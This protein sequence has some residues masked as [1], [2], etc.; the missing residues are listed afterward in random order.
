MRTEKQKARFLATCAYFRGVQHATCLAGVEMKTVRDGSGK[1]P[2]RWPC[3]PPMMPGQ[4]CSTTC[5]KFQA[6]TVEE[7]EEEERKI[8][9]AIHRVGRLTK[10]GRCYVCEAE[11]D[12]TK[13][14][15][16]CVYLLP[17]GH[18]YGQA[19]EFSVREA[20]GLTERP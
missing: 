16:H 3:L 20:L 2:Y 15:G 13:Q 5:R 8:A 9:E 1:G 18:R 14:S 4:V 7:Y 6:Q 17:C 10:E 12:D 11:V 19:K